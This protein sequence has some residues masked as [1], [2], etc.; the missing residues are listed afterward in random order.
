[1]NVG[2]LSIYLNT[3]LIVALTAL[4]E[5]LAQ[6]EQVFKKTSALSEELNQVCDTVKPYRLR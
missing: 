1:M 4:E 2:H 5:R 3:L 6:V